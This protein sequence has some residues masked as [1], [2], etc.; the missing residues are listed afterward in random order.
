MAHA[1][2]WR[3]PQLRYAMVIAAVLNTAFQ[4]SVFLAY[5]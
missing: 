4:G 2:L 5:R 1:F 3:S